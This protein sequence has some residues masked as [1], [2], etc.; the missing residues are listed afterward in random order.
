MNIWIRRLSLGTA[1]TL[2]S[3]SMAIAAN[4]G[5]EK[6]APDKVAA[7][8][9]VSGQPANLS[10]SVDTDDGPVYFCCQDCIPKFRA[11][12][13]KYADKVAAQRKALEG[14]EKVQV[15]CPVSGE[16]VDPTVSVESMG[17]K[18]YFCCP[19]CVKKFQKDPAKYHKALLN[20]FAYQTKCPI[21][22]KAIDPSAFATSHSGQ[23]VYFCC[24]KCKMAFTENP[25]K[26]ASN[27]EEQGIKVDPDDW[28]DE[29]AEPQGD[30][31]D[32]GHGHGGGH[33]G[34]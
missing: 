22:G 30:H 2:A 12:P 3:V 5:D 34:R 23:T 20:S 16:S 4:G 26:Y 25:A 29:D 27:L 21:S 13:A 11:D 19:G 14:R 18:V 28:G 9:P 1:L 31:G 32:S 7:L 33:H 17:H 24:P 15:R 8:C 6:E 10:V